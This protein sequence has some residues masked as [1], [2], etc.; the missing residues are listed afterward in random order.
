VTIAFGLSKNGVSVVTLAPLHMTSDPA[1]LQHQA[2]TSEAS[3]KAV[4]APHRRRR[5]GAVRRD[6]TLVSRRGAV[7]VF[8]LVG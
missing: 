8:R 5:R 3:G 4:T 1:V 7:K 2:C 6:T